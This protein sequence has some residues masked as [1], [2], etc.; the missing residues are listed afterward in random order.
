MSF[1]GI[2]FTYEMRR[3]VV[4]AKKF[5]SENKQNYN[6]F[7][8]TCPYKLTSLVLG[9]AESTVRKIT[10]MFNKK[11]DDFLIIPN[12]ENR[13][14]PPHNIED[15]IETLI[16][17][18]VR[19]SNKSGIQIT[20]ESIRKYLKENLGLD[21]KLTTLWRTLQRWGFEFGK[22]VRSARLKESERIIILRRQYLRE[23]IKNRKPNGCT[24]RPEIYLD[25]SYINKNHSKDASWFIEGE[26]RFLSKP[27]GK[28]ERLIIVNA[29]SRNGWIPNAKHVFKS[30]RNTGDYHSNMNWKVFS[31][32]FEN[33]LLPNIPPESI[34]IL[35]NAKYHNVLSEE[36]FPQKKNTIMH[37]R[38]WLLNNG[39]PYTDDMIKSELFKLCSERCPKPEFALDKIAMR[40]GHSIL[41]TPPY[42][43]ELQPIEVCWAI[44]KSHV[45]RNNDFSNTKI[46]DLLEEGFNKVTKKTMEGILTKVQSFE[47]NFWCDDS[48]AQEDDIVTSAQDLEEFD[49]ED[50]EGET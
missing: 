12:L 17:R 28:G 19:E 45:A 3:L 48:R 26:D 36:S 31:E 9:I 22:G 39:I 11:L 10:T 16:R 20:T 50:D 21:V 44:V 13:G 43:P 42:H 34:I 29:V 7:N 37:L 18:L 1:Q 38:Y 15:G 24:I 46:N 14:H 30:K 23:K 2:E 6:A 27:T 4:N 25:E 32:W 41:R 47:D 33:K 40:Y 5:F 49:E 35:D 8:T